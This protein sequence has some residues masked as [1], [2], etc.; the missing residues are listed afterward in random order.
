MKISEL[1]LAE[2]TGKARATIRKWLAN[3]P[4][5]KGPHKARLYES[6][7]AL[8]ILY[9]GEPESGETLSLHEEQRLLTKARREEIGLNMEVVRKER[10]PL[11][12][13]TAINDRAFSNI[14]GILKARLGKLF[15]DETLQDCFAELRGIGERIRELGPAFAPGTK[16]IA[17]FASITG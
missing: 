3:T 4:H 11:D 6:K 2:L 15:D 1:R 10:I 9:R 17:P 7:V 16:D 12:E 13:I 8:E 14:A 5:E